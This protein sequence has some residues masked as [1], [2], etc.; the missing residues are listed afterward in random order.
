VAD[1]AG[2]QLRL[3]DGRT[4]AWGEQGDPSGLPVLAL[5][6]T[7][8]SRHHMLVYP[9]AAASAGARLIA[10]DR[11]GYGASTFHAGRTF[12]DFADDLTE[13]ADHLGL[14]RFAVAGLS[15][16]GPHALASAAFLGRR[17]TAVALLSGIGPVWERGSEVGMMRANRVLTRL[18]RPVPAATR[19]P[20]GL[21]AT[22]G[23]RFPDATLGRAAKAFAPADAAMLDRPEVVDAFRRDLTT[24]SATTG[25]AASQDFALAARPWGFR[26][27]DV[28]VPTFLWQGDDDRN[29]PLA[30]ARAM[31]A[32][33]PGAVL[34]V[35]PGGGHLASVDHLEE[36]YAEVV[37][38]SR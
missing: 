36:I 25:R 15:G 23:R 34:H 14:D 1:D 29:V 10:L 27:E 22:M 20:F 28:A 18:S 7:P 24:A 37:A 4:L 5:H 8:G 32:A 38:A 3:R 16:G 17:V 30:H 13:L 26:L 21:M 6:G 33:L 35:I 9:E 2:S 31:A 19:L 12:R 11:P